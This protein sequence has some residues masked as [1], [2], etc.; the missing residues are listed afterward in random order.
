MTKIGVGIGE[1]FPIEDKPGASPGAGTGQ[2]EEA[3]GPHEYD[4][5]GDSRYTGWGYCCDWD[6]EDWYRRRAEWRRA[7]HEWRRQRHEWR[8]RFRAE[9]RARGYRG[10][11][12]PFFPFVPLLVVLIVFSLLITGLMTVLFSA[13]FAVLGLLFVAVLYGVHRSHRHGYGDYGATP[14]SGPAEGPAN[15]TPPA[16]PAERV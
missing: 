6:R 11:G 9:M 16:P 7:R 3:P 10:R 13:P 5:D 12:F 1:D 4:P 14:A 2:G 8:R 15:G